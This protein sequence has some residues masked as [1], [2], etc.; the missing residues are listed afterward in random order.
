V[1]GV[2]GRL[3]IAAMKANL[4]ESPLCEHLAEPVGLIETMKRYCT[5]ATDGGLGKSSKCKSAY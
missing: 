1:L 2:T 3:A 4:T 5:V